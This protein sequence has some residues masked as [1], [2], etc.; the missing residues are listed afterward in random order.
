MGYQTK[1]Q[2]QLHFTC[3]L[4][5]SERAHLEE[6][7]NADI[8]EH[9][10]WGK[11]DEY[12]TY[13]DL[14]FTEDLS[15]IEWNPDADKTYGMRTA[16]NVIIKEMKKIKPEFGLSGKLLAQGENLEDR[17][18]LIIGEDGYA[19]EVGTPPVDE[20]IQCPHCKQLFFYKPK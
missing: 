5:A 9:R 17:W 19:K 2:G 6:F 13:I 11:S 10:E 20:K 12:A 14:Q 4:S 8:R 1:F 7:F 15:G 16:V 18:A 3:E